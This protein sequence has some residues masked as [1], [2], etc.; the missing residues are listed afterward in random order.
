LLTRERLEGL[1]IEAFDGTTGVVRKHRQ[2]REV[3][4][5]AFDRVRREPAFDS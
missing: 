1:A 4:A 3:A 2:R 5:V